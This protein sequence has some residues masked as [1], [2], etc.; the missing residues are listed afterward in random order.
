LFGKAL[1]LSPQSVAALAGLGRADLAQR[2]F[3]QAAQHLQ[4]ALEIDPQSESL[5]APLAVAYR[6]LGQL[7]KA[8]PHLRQWRNTD[9][10]LPDPLQQELDLVLESG[11][12]YELRGVR[13]LDSKDFPAA[14]NFFRRGLDLAEPGTPLHRSLQHKLGT[15]LFATR[16]VDAAMR[17]F[18]GVVR[19]APAE[20]IDESTAKAHYSLGILAAERGRE[21][22]T[23]THLAAAIRY[24]PSYLEAH[25]GLG[26][27]LRHQGRL[28]DALHEY[29]EAIAINPR[30]PAGRLGHAIALMGLHRE[31]E[32]R[33]WLV[34]SMTGFPDRPQFAHALARVLVTAADAHVRDPQ[35]ATTIVQGLFEKDKST[36]VGETMAMTLAELGEYEQAAGIQRGVLAAAKRTRMDAAVPRLEANLRLYEQGH[37]CRTAWRNDEPV[38][39]PMPVI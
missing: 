26:D 17:E 21:A 6:G 14:T 27:A 20:G 30:D 34:E 22:E 16:Q 2:D 13:A 24:Q 28:R 10:L 7:D 4:A 35:R 5:H 36:S 33:D 12:S 32:A 9:I 29:D 38:F 23:Q 1:A 39:L 25:L 15:A 8:E 11:L 31:R 37:P 19:S 3:A 18:E